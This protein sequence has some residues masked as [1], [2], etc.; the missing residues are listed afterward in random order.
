KVQGISGGTAGEPA[1]LT[2]Q[3]KELGAPT[4]FTA[5]QAAD[6]QT[7]LAMAGFKTNEINGAI[8]GMLG[9]AAAGHLELGQAAEITQ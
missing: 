4:V 3:A 1:Q 5:S 9:L 7:F 2:A 8:P 6:A